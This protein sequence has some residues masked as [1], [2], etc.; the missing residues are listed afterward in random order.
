MND[1]IFFRATRCSFLRYPGQASSIL[2]STGLKQTNMQEI[3]SAN[4][5]TNQQN[6]RWIRTEKE[7]LWHYEAIRC[8]VYVC[9]P[10]RTSLCLLWCETHTKSLTVRPP[11]TPEVDEERKIPEKKGQM[12]KGDREWQLKQRAEEEGRLE[13]AVQGKDD[14]QK[15]AV[16]EDIQRWVGIP[17]GK[18]HILR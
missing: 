11:A 10:V 1:F 5:R 17:S 13:I 2:W 18:V 6:A 12:T 4:S 3:L 14:Q 15:E 8:I 9:A 16:K 7:T